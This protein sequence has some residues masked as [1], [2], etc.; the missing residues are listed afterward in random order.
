MNQTVW[1]ILRDRSL[2]FSGGEGE[3]EGNLVFGVTTVAGVM[4]LMTKRMLVLKQVIL[5]LI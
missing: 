4:F 5:H 2:S 3:V 1:M